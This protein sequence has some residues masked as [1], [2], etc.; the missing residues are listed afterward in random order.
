MVQEVGPFD[1]PLVFLESEISMYSIVN[2]KKMQ[3]IGIQFLR[4][5]RPEELLMGQIM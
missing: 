4:L 1:R 3:I 2:K 5:L